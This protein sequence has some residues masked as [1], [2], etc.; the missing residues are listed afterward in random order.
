[1]SFVAKKHSLQI[2]TADSV[3]HNVISK[4]MAALAM[5]KWIVFS[6]SGYK[7]IVVHHNLI[8]GQP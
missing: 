5:Q 4:D 7:V 6:L 3:V 1:M 2:V 8:Q